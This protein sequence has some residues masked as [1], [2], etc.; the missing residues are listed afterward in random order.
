MKPIPYYVRALAMAIPAMLIGVQIPTWF[1]FVPSRAIEL[2]ADFRVLYTAG[3]MAR[4]GQSKDLYNYRLVQEVQARTIADDGAAVPFIHPAVEALL[5]VPI[6][7]LPYRAA[8]LSWIIVNCIVLIAIY[9]LLRPRVD[10]L[11]QLFPW[12]PAA[13]L[14]SFFPISFAILQG[15]DS[16]LL[17]LAVVLAFRNIAKN[18]LWAG[19]LL[20][21][22]MFR[23]QVLLPVLALFLWWRAWRLVLGWLLTSI[24]VLAASVAVAGI[25][26]QFQLFHLLQSMAS[27]PYLELT[28]RMV[29]LRGLVT[30]V[31]GGVFVT[32]TLSAIVLI[33]VAW[34]VKKTAEQ[35]F[36]LAVA[37]S[38]LVAYHFFLHDLCI[39]AAPAMTAFDQALCRGEW[40]NL[41]FLSL[42]FSLPTIV[43][44]A[45][46][47]IYI[48]ALSPLAL[49]LGQM[50]SDAI[51]RAECATSG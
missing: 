33:A 16:L 7:L 6:S 14:L 10:T 18:E 31:G 38:C 1:T 35:R 4:T 12:L 34:Q 19:L 25:G 30:A 13:L 46:G 43:W 8:Y 44:F 23:F 28:N 26:G 39:L 51:I 11:A 50:K 42:A 36:L 21:L 5:F 3:Y 22:G 37:V 49:L 29:N 27:M 15:Q 47:P 17:L 40:K 45:H 20:G 41:G 24:G 2:Q 9:K 48:M 32:I